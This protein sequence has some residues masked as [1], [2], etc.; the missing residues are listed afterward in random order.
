M[1]H[2]SPELRRGGGTRQRQHNEEKA[3]NW[4]EA[5]FYS[6]VAIVAGLTAWKLLD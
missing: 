3:V 6:I 4:P 5:F 1:T 2:L